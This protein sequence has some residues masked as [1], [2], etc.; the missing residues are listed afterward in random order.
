[1][2][3][4]L[5]RALE[6]RDFLRKELAAVENFIFDYQRITEL[7]T[8]SATV[9]SQRTLFQTPIKKRK[10]QAAT[11]RAMIDQAE[12]M[13]LAEGRPLTRSQLVSRLEAGGHHIEGGDKNKV[14]GTNMWRSG[15]FWNIRR[16]GYW[17]KSAPIPP[18][19]A[20]LEKR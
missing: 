14:F 13:I 9:P 5:Q 6:R 19:F 7:N 10:E 12:R 18:A 17:P 4:L 20:D 2:D 8:Q 11:V 3:D 16:A 1:M 15:R